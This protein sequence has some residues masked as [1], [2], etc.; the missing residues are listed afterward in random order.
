MSPPRKSHATR[1]SPHSM[2]CIGLSTRTT[3]RSGPK[4]RHVNGGRPP[5]SSAAELPIPATSQAR[6]SSLGGGHL[7]P[8]SVR[9]S[10]LSLRSPLSTAGSSPCSRLSPSLSV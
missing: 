8:L 4:A 3:Y 9:L 5:Q 10:R 1:G 2:H 7:K 6:R